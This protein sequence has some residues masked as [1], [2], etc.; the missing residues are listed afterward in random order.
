MNGELA[1]H[2][3]IWFLMRTDAPITYSGDAEA[4]TARPTSSRSSPRAAAPMKLFVDQA[5]HLPLMLSYEGVL[6][7]M[8]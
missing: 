7:R 8:I 4:Q 5:T 3:L 2:A 1:R 6:P